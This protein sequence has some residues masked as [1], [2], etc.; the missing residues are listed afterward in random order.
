MKTK[1]R[2]SMELGVR[3]YDNS[4]ESGTIIGGERGMLKDYGSR[5]R[6]RTHKSVMMGTHPEY[7]GL[8][9]IRTAQYL[10]VQD[11]S[12]TRINRLRK[13]ESRFHFWKNFF[14]AMNFVRVF[15]NILMR[16]NPFASYHVQVRYSPR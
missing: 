10:E 2:P 3:Y 13:K 9:F 15:N 1:T 6:A 8:R 14:E 7:T 5:E 12:K 11:S 4:N 16:Y